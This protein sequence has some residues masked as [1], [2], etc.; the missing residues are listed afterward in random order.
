MIAIIDG[1]S[2]SYILGWNHREHQDVEL[3]KEATHGFVHTICTL[4]GATSYIG[5]LSPEKNFRYDTYKYAPYKGNR[6]RDERPE[7]QVFWKPIIDGYL[8][9]QWA[10][11][12][13]EGLEADDVVALLSE[14]FSENKWNHVICS[15][16]KDLRQIP[17]LHYDY[18]K[19]GSQ[20][21]TVSDDQAHYNFWYQM[22]IGDTTDNIKGVPGL[23]EKK[24]EALLKSVEPLMY[25]TTVKLAYNKY[26]GD[27]YGQIIFK[28]TKDAV[29]L[30]CSR[31]SLYLGYV[32]IIQ[33]LLNNHL[34]E[35]NHIGIERSP[36][37]EI[38][39]S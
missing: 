27:H 31:H 2:I 14:G 33:S 1:D 20:V 7:W 28:E 37:D 9:E 19:E 15:P 13:V 30:L 26:F 11:F 36:F 24:A 23:G 39:R 12:H 22:L 8:K 35:F 25:E 4:V 10:F 3:M 16:D 32:P 34:I 29:Q 38:T 5:L 17:G 18:K 6:K 21:E